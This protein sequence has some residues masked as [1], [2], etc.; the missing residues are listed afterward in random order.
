MAL[1]LLGERTVAAASPANPV[2]AI[3]RWIAKA[4]AARTRRVALTSL[5]ELDHAQLNDLGISRSDVTAALASKG[6]H[7]S[8]SLNA[9]RAR[10]ARR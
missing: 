10:N 6:L 7:S 8:Q 3:L 4:Q 9:A 1:S 2:V 5:L